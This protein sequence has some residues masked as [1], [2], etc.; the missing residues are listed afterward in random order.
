MFSVFQTQDS[1]RTYTDEKRSISHLY[2]CSLSSIKISDHFRDIPKKLLKKV[3]PIDASY[4]IWNKRTQVRFSRRQ[5]SALNLTGR[6]VSM[7]SNI[8]NPEFDF[9]KEL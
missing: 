4:G 6:A 2:F 5:D 3:T 7:E 8:I 9:S 1:S